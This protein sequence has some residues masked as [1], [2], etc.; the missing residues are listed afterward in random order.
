MGKIRLAIDY[1]FETVRK[2]LYLG[3][4]I[5][6]SSFTCEEGVKKLSLCTFRTLSVWFKYFF[7]VLCEL[8]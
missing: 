2:N 1:R 7:A 8:S 5:E 3:W 4:R 6:E